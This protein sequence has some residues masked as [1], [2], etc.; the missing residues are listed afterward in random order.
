MTPDLTTYDIILVNSS[1][2]KDSQAMLDLLVEMADGAGVRDRMVVV[3][4]DLGRMEWSGTRELAEEQ[5]AHY[6]LRFEVVKREG[7]EY[8]GR[9]LGDLLD[10]VIERHEA[11]LANGKQQ[12]PWP[13][14]TARWCTSDQK[15]AQVLKLIVRLTKEKAHLGRKVRIL[16]CLGLRADESPAR[17]KKPAFGFDKQASNGLRHVDRWLPIHS[18]TID[19]VWERIRQSGV[20]HHPAYDQGMPRLSCS[21]C[22]LASRGA[23]IRAAQL[24]PDLAAEYVSVE[25]R[26]G[27]RFRND[28]S[29][30][31]IVAAAE[32]EDEVA[33]TSWAA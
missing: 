19:Q 28:L 3:H 16:N 32:A 27:W 15:T 24:R 5:A 21:F 14:S 25:E 20:P 18:W 10:Q 26:V 13:S 29:M 22:I 1:A 4:C 31:D 33:I 9:V 23:L 6:G 11:N 2:G 30:A 8:K 7:T 17:A 12:P